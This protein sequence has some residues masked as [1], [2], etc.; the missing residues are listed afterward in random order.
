M[1]SGGVRRCL[2]LVAGAL[3]LATGCGL[4]RGAARMPMPAAPRRAPAATPAGDLTRPVSLQTIRRF[5]PRLTGA[6]YSMVGT[7]PD[8]TGGKGPTTGGRTGTDTGRAPAGVGIWGKADVPNVQLLVQ[9]SVVV[10]VRGLFAAGVAANLAFLGTFKYANFAGS[11]VAALAGMQHSPW[12]LTLFVPIGISFHTFQ[13]ISY[14]VDV[15][16]G[17][18]PK[19]VRRRRPT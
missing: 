16:R 4:T 9:G 11:T 10:G 12:L 3:L 1:K 13:S 18:I 6:G 14:L 5:N 15:Y 17:R 2:A 8:V 7:L 19:S